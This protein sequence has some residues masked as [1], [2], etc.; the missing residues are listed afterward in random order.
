MS[1]A[2]E[3][4][5]ALGSVGHFCSFPV[6]SGTVPR[7]RVSLLGPTATRAAGGPSESPWWRSWWSCTETQCSISASL[8]LGVQ[9]SPVL[10]HLEPIWEWVKAGASSLL[11]PEYKCV[12]VSLGSFW[13]K[14]H[15]KGHATRN[16]LKEQT[17]YR[18]W[19]KDIP[20]PMAQSFPNFLQALLNVSSLKTRS[21][22][23]FWPLKLGEA[24]L[25]L[26]KPLG[27]LS[28]PSWVPQVQMF[29]E[30]RHCPGTGVLQCLKCAEQHM[31][32]C[33][34]ANLPLGSF[35]R[36]FS[37]TCLNKPIYVCRTLCWSFPVASL[38]L[39]HALILVAFHHFYSKKTAVY[40]DKC[41]G[42]GALTLF[43]HSVRRDAGKLK[44]WQL[45]R[46]LCK[47]LDG[48]ISTSDFQFSPWF[49]E[50]L[51]RQTQPCLPRLSQS[52][53]WHENAL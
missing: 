30:H 15:R 40:C 45:P 11:L 47:K 31:K 28:E 12:S 4:H 6:G 36:Q 18:G 39:N 34:S 50:V 24:E 1:N 51:P 37:V 16:W 8:P 20:S 43:F 2:I 25:A 38:P 52:S 29:Q 17:S 53:L 41:S 3:E 19:S 32:V 27:V 7:C 44:E 5:A 21:D 35:Q 49:P 23:C 42:D 10:H 9:I 46:G 48:V 14:L 33:Y 13:E 22:T 26:G